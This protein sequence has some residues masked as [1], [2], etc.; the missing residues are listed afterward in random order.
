MYI[1]NERNPNLQLVSENI[2]PSLPTVARKAPSLEKA[3]LLIE[4]WHI[5]HLA[6]GL[7]CTYI[8]EIN[9]EILS[10]VTDNNPITQMYLL[11]MSSTSPKNQ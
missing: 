5:C 11:F 10:E 8:E 2:L 9:E 4:P 6:T 3:M 7:L 1:A